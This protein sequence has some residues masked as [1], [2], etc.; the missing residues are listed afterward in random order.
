MHHIYNNWSQEEVESMAGFGYAVEEGSKALQIEED[1]SYFKIKPLL[2]KWEVMDV[3]YPEFTKEELDSAEWLV[4]NGNWDNGYPMPDGDGSYKNITYDLTEY[5]NECG[6]GLVQKAPFRIK[7]EPKWGKQKMFNL[8]WIPD[9]IFSEKDFYT[10][11]FKPMGVGSRPVLIHKTGKEAETAI[12]LELPV[13]NQ[14]LDVSNFPYEIC[15]TCGR[16]KYHALIADFIHSY[17]IDPPF[18]IFKGKEYF[19]SGGSAFRRIFLSQEI[20]QGLLKNKAAKPTMF[21]PLR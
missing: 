10:K 1:E 16:K 20:R 11:F 2:E 6:Q 14:D 9:E 4:F 19:G 12:Q 13:F 7:S 8:N 5:C 18:T 17:K 3:K 21:I 15:K